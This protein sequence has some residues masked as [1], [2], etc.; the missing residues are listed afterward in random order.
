MSVWTPLPS[1][2]RDY[3]LERSH[4]F[5]VALIGASD[6]IGVVEDIYVTRQRPR[7]LLVVSG[8]LGRVATIVRVEEV[9]SIHPDEGLIVLTRDSG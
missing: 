4:G 9:T 6:D 7:L 5:R 2:D 8:L 3:W 1:S